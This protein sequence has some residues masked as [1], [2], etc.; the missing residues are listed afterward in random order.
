MFHIDGRIA[1]CSQILF[2]ICSRTSQYTWNSLIRPRT[3]GL[4][5]SCEMII[6]QSKSHGEII[7]VCGGI[8]TTALRKKNIVKFSIKQPHLTSTV[9]RLLSDRLLCWKEPIWESYHFYVHCV[10]KKMAF[11]MCVIT[12]AS[13]CVHYSFFLSFSFSLGAIWR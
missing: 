10:H 1:H 13:P 2:Q 12:Y 3:G 4:S 6:L 7:R 11:L 5:S 9:H 8:F